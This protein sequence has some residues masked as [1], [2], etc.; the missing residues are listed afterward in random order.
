MPYRSS[1]GTKLFEAAVIELKFALN[2]SKL[3][4]HHSLVFTSMLQ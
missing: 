4:S 2:K 1:I 3:I